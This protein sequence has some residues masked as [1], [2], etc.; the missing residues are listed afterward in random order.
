[1]LHICAYKYASPCLS[2]PLSRS[3]SDVVTVSFGRFLSLPLSVPVSGCL[4]ICLSVS[5]P[6]LT[7]SYRLSPP[8][9]S[10]SPSLWLSLSL[11]LPSLPPAPFLSSLRVCLLSPPLSPS[12]HPNLRMSE[13]YVMK[14]VVSDN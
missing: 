10:V 14:T 11:S 12:S 5:P 8:R 7:A 1:M 6:P 3:L 2:L 13:A 9:L 4:H